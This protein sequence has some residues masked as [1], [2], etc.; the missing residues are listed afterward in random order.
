[1]ALLVNLSEEKQLRGR[2]G[3]VEHK[4]TFLRLI[5]HPFGLRGCFELGGLR[6]DLRPEKTWKG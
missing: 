1:M 2:R 3:S 4:G 5:V 6:A